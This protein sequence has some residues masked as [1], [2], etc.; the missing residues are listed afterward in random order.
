M[1][2]MALLHRIL[3]LGPTPTGRCKPAVRVMLCSPRSPYKLHLAP[4]PC[5]DSLAYYLPP[6]KSQLAPRSCLC[7]PG[8]I[9]APHIFFCFI[10]VLNR[11]TSFCALRIPV[12]V[13]M[14]RSFS[15]QQQLQ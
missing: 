11:C 4:P 10:Q 14:C 9:A 5:A 8:C 2:G 12:H 3:W 1:E 15:G 6:S 7:L 13:T